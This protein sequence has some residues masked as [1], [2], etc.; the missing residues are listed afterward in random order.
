MRTTL[1]ALFMGIFAI[2]GLKAQEGVTPGTTTGVLAD[3]T[4]GHEKVEK[5]RFN[6]HVAGIYGGFI[7]YGKSDY[8]AYKNK[9]F[10]KLKVQT[11][12]TV[13]LNII[14]INIGLQKKKNT[15]GFV[16]GAGAEFQNM[17]FEHKVAIR[18]NDKGVVEPFTY[19]QG[20]V[21]SSRLRVASVNVPL[22]LEFQSPANK[23]S[24]FHFG[25]GAVGSY[26][27]Y[28]QT[29][30]KVS[31]NYFPHLS[32]TYSH[33]QD[34]SMP[35]W[36]FDAMVQ[37]GWNHFTLWARYGLTPLFDEGK[38]PE[39]HQLSFGAAIPF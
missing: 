5:I 34:F 12:Y 3:S 17:E 29:K 33:K 26:N 1:L 2:N 14:E 7:T 10:M 8:S 27:F 18:E 6:G 19:G 39:L 35:R 31:D 38:G 24:R 9:D 30:V 11:S 15:V 4:V 25:V 20:H 28:T 13:A 22:M 23:K 37:M 16:L 36:N 21:T 32:K